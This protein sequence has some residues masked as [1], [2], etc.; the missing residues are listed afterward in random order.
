[1]PVIFS[2]KDKERIRETLFKT[3]FERIKKYGCKKVL[4]N[5]V[6]E[7]AGIAK[8]TFYN[9]FA[10][11]EEFIFEMIRYN[12]DRN[13]KK[14]EEFFLRG[15]PTEERTRQFFLDKYLQ[16]DISI[17]YIK[18]DDLAW[19]FRK[20]PDKLEQVKSEA[21][22]FMGTLLEAILDKSPKA[23]LHVVVNMMNII[24]DYVVNKDHY[25]EKTFEPTIAILVDALVTYIFHTK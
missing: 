13:R 16:E 19:L 9:F 14:A 10:S 1:M 21:I 3:G 4:I 15:N 22:S 18:R 5:E 23:Q 6:A 12:R 24:A 8:G 2:D 25:F 7:D 20:N 11:K 17:A